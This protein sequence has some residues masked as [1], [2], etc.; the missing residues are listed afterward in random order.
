MTVGDINPSVPVINRK[1]STKSRRKNSKNIE[2]INPQTCPNGH[3]YNASL[4]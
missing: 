1:K 4:E 3:M 2:E